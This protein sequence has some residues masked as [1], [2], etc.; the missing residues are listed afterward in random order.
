[1]DKQNL[2]IHLHDI[3]PLVEIQEYSLYYFLGLVFIS[4]VI[5][6]VIGYF[7]YAWWRKKKAYSVRKEHFEALKNIDL[8]DSKKAAYA[9][10]LYG[11]TF[12]N[13]GE[14]QAK[15]FHNIVEKLDQYKYKK[16]IDET[17]DEETKGYIELY[18]G[19]LDV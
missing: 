19:M 8:S 12:K 7:I 15:M 18:I 16:V 11:A 14:R 10:T 13:D 3:K 2:D 1:M 6:G 4:L 9:L 5:L 17:I